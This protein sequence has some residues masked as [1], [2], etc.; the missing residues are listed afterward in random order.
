MNRYLYRS[1]VFLLAFQAY[2]NAFGW[3]RTGHRAIGYIAWTH[4]TPAAKTRI[5]KILDGKSIA[6]VSNWMD[7]IKSDPE[8]DYTHPWH[9]CTIPDGMTYEEAGTP[10]EGDVIVTVERLIRELETKQFSK[11]DR[12]E[13]T[14]LKFLIHLIGDV[15]QPLH[16]GNG[17]DRGG[18]DVRVK[19]FYYNSNLH[20]VWDE[21]MIDHKKWSASEMA[22]EFDVAPPAMIDQWQ[23][24]DVRQWAMESVK[25]RPQIYDI[26]SDHKLGWEY[27]YK[28][29]PVVELRILQAGIRLA[30]VLNR[31]YG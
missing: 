13:A 14:A 9:Y 8:Y 6:Y 21:D 22:V 28:N 26:P 11:E 25:F 4:L 3:G 18:N 30:G 29:W 15:H 5:S 31:I 16:T 27:E 7:D 24:S 19:W 2:F 23:K 10:K 17:K 12:D 1:L 20:R